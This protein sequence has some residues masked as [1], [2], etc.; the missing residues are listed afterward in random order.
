MKKTT[1]RHNSRLVPQRP[2]RKKSFLSR[3]RSQNSYRRNRKQGSSGRTRLKGLAWI[4]AFLTL[5]GLSLGL[6]VGYHQLLTCS[7]FCIK[8]INHIEI[9]GNKR[10]SRSVVL[11]Q[12]RVTPGASLLAIRPGQVEHSLMAHPWIARAEVSRKWPNSL[13]IL[14]QEREPVALVQIGAELR[15]VDR[16]GM[17]FKPLT[18]GD[19]HNFPVITGLGPD[20]FRHPD[21]AL[22][23]VVAQVFHLLDMLKK[24]LPP[25]NLGNISEVHVD[26]ERGFTLYANGL[27]APLDLGLDNHA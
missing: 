24:T 12:A 16:Q 2:V 1:A 3:G 20:Q 5:A 9:D 25:L 6:L 23:K 14:I 17:L 8:D 11:Q 19:P 21:E 7:V 26:P 4:L 18:P 13:H 15:Y 10:L 27:G 22:P